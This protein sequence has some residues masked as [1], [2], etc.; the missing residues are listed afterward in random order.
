SN[1]KVPQPKEAGGDAS[2]EEVSLKELLQEVRSIRTIQQGM[3]DNDD[4]INKKL[5]AIQ[6][7]MK[8]IRK[9]LE[10]HSMDIKDLKQE[11][12]RKRIVLFNMEGEPNEPRSALEANLGP[13]SQCFTSLYY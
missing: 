6:S 1:K 9:E 8:P 11:K 4:K 2:G 12:Y 13:V 10:T 3:I 7:G 5:D